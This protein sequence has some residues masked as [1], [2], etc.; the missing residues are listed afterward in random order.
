[1]L[2]QFLTP[3]NIKKLPTILYDVLEFNAAGNSV[4]IYEHLFPYTLYIKTAP[5]CRL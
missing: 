1:M 2:P 3:F 5:S 4:A